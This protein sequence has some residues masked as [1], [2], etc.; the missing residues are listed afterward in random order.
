MATLDT[1]AFEQ[2]QALFEGDVADVLDSYIADSL[3]QIEDMTRAVN[4]GDRDV[5]KIN[6][7]SLKSSSRSVGAM[8]VGALAEQLEHLACRSGS[9]D[10]IKLVVGRLRW[11]RTAA[12][13][14]LIELKP[15]V[16]E[17]RRPS[18]A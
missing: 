14:R 5:L 1:A 3:A 13:A 17:P 11:A 16:Q 10:E 2:L 12:V 7:H 6:A 15:Q 4:A 9:M 8:Q 18:R